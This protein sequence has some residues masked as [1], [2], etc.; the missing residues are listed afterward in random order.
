VK[1][2]DGNGILKNAS[3][4]T[5]PLTT[6]HHQ[7]ALDVITDTV[8][9]LTLKFTAHLTIPLLDGMHY[10]RAP[11]RPPDQSCSISKNAQAWSKTLID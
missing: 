10:V 4:R 11:T 6:N 7:D 5:A 9:T 1:T 2:A 8:H 3:R